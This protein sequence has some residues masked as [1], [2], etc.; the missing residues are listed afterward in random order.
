MTQSW[1]GHGAE[2]GGAWC[3]VGWGMVQ[4]W[5]GHDAESGGA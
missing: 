5:V 2:L 4:S 1:V 3:R